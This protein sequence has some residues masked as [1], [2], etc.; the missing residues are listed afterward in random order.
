M[1]H[2]CYSETPKDKTRQQCR[3]L[4]FIILCLL[5]GGCTEIRN[6]YAENEK[7]TRN[8]SIFCDN[9]RYDSSISLDATVAEAI[10]SVGVTVNDADIV[11][12]VMPMAIPADGIIR[13]TRVTTEDIV[14]E[15]VIPFQSQTVRNE[16]L[17]D[18][19]TRLIQ[20]GQNGTRQIVTRYTYE[21]G[22]QTAKA[23]VS[24][25]TIKESVPEIIMRG[26]K[27][28]YAPIKINGR[29]IYI[30]EGSAWMMEGSTEN[31]TPL[32]STG[33][34]DGR[35][36]DLSSDGQWLLFSRTGRSTEVNGLWMVNVNDWNAEPISLRVSNV[37]HFAS[38]LPGNTRRF[39][40]SSVEPSDQ[41]PGWKALNDLRMQFVSDTGMLMTQEEILGPDD[42]GDYAWWGTEFALSDDARQL[43]FATPEK[44]GLIDRLTGEKEE[45]IN[46]T[47]Y[48]KT[49]S[50]WAWI[51]GFCWNSE[52]TG[53]YFTFHGKTD[54]EIQTFD[55]TDYHIAF[56]DLNTGAFHTVV[57]NAGLFSYPTISPR[58]S[59]GKSYLTW[60]QSE[61]PQQVESE[62]Y[63]IMISDK[64][65]AN[66]RT[67][68]PSQS[69]SGYIT[70]QHLV[71]SPGE[72]Q[73]SAWIA[74]L[75]DGNIWLVNPFAGIHNQI[76]SDGTVS[77]FIWE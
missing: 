71:W 45:L 73:S 76:T 62:R 58:F 60:L 43:L 50:D 19:E 11:I 75:S 14:S 38:W 29:L 1:N 5:L 23:V 34:L 31:R 57:K 27:A 22:V 10:R 74:F 39:V 59:N 55:P 77:R 66:V 12:P 51:P 25:V 24:V 47:P 35:V 6:F 49:R 16:S 18:G 61:L 44:L 42:N 65:G 63:R 48:E 68:Y 53:F 54:G 67:V 9:I 72:T 52:N 8:I 40:Y 3:A 33:D 32:V 2:Q 17:P 46:F 28:E 56:Y 64:D 69:S 15:Q 20:Q 41:T 7:P 21:D 26:A 13:I 30:S 37:L 4:F 36:L 70:P